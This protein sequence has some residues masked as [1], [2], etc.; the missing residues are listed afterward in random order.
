MALPVILID[1]AT[2]SDSA[3]SGA[4]PAT[5]LTGS[6]ASTSGT[7]LVVTLDGS[8]SLANV[9]TDG[10]HVIYLADTTAGTRN[11]GK[12]TGKDD[13]AKTVTVSD[14]FGLNL[15]N[16]AWAIGGMRASLG[17]T[18]SKKLYDNNS[19]NGDAMPGWVI[20]YQSGST[21]TFSASLRWYRAGDTTSGPIELRGAA[22]AATMP[23]LTLSANDRFFDPSGYF[24]MRDLEFR[25]TNATKTLSCVFEHWNGSNSVMMSGCR[26]THATDKFNRLCFAQSGTTKGRVRIEECEI[27]NCAGPGMAFQN[28]GSSMVAVENCYIHNNAGD[29]I[30]IVKNYLAQV[31]VSGCV[32]SGNGGAG[33]SQTSSGSDVGILHI[34]GNTIVSNSGSGLASSSLL[35][36]A[37]ATIEN[38]ILANNGGYGIAWTSG[39][40]DQRI[41]QTVIR[42]NNTYSNSSGA[43][44]P[45]GIGTNDPGLDPQFANAAGGDYAIGA[46]LKGLGYPTAYLGRT[47]ATLSRV[48]IGAAQRAE[49]YAA[50]VFNRAKRELIAGLAN[51]E[52]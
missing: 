38:N 16:K 8:P 41:A 1:S 18:T 48:D 36:F 49:A 24:T 37:L 15:T 12:I 52:G 39:P 29:G 5:A 28:S 17:S 13:G 47:S 32:I 4:G 23:I 50:N 2:G 43:Y 51:L 21:E 19:G 6:A 30:A 46:T 27:A 11:F 35:G 33:I 45:A 20:E 22:G 26:V 14:A 3:A 34:V 44:S 42:N 31:T 9:A 40:S 10:S 7:G 25:N